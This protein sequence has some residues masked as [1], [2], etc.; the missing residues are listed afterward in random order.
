MGCDKMVPFR[1]TPEGGRGRSLRVEIDT[2]ERIVRS[3]YE[4][5]HHT[6]G[7]SLSGRREAP[8]GVEGGWG[9][10]G[11]VSDPIGVVDVVP[12]QSGERQQLYWSRSPSASGRPA[13]VGET[14][15]A[16]RTTGLHA[17]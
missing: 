13:A 11:G 1:P 3:G 16:S 2:G 6:G 10:T 5:D 14:P 17:M 7:H 15:V 4:A 8:R 9:T 12:S